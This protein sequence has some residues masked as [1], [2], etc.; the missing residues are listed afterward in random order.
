[1]WFKVDDQLAFHRKT[2]AAG[3]AAMGLWVRAGSWARSPQGYKADTPG[4]LTYDEARSMGTAAEIRR[5][6]DAGL[7]EPC[8]LGGRKAVRFHDWPEFQPDAD[9]LDAKRADWALRKRRQRHHKDGDHSLCLERYC[10]DA[11]PLPD[12]PPDEDDGWA[13][14]G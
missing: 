14:H 1:M 11:P 9:N 4:V 5:L 2:L 3:N 12:E 10:D 7:W 6:I 8:K 13:D